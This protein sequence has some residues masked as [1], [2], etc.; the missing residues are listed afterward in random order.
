M[1]TLPPTHLPTNPVKSGISIL[2]LWLYAFLAID[3]LCKTANFGHYFD[4]LTFDFLLEPPEPSI[5]YFHL[6]IFQ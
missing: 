6:A 4:I 3:I 1:D 5:G 2:K